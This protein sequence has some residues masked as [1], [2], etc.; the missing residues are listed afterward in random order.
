MSLTIQND[1]IS[2]TTDNPA[3]QMFSIL[4]KKINQELL[5]QADEGWSGRNP[6]LFR[7]LVPHGKKG[8]MSGKEKRIK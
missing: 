5:Y 3:G 8:N 6:S 2:L 1:R 4:D 7:W